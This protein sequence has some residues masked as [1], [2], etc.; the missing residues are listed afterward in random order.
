MFGST[1]NKIRNLVPVL[2]FF[3]IFEIAVTI[4]FTVIYGINSIYIYIVIPFDAL[5]FVAAWL[6]LSDTRRNATY[7]IAA[8]LLNMLGRILLIQTTI[9]PFEFIWPAIAMFLGTIIAGIFGFYIWLQLNTLA[10]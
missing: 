2:V 8:L 6:L 4:Y 7:A 1:T 5:Y 10:T 9:Y 3:G